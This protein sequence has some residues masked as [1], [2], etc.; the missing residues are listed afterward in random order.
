[1]FKSNL[2]AFIL[3]QA[4]AIPQQFFLF[5]LNKYPKSNPHN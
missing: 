2:R 1:L 5:L 4:C 3:K